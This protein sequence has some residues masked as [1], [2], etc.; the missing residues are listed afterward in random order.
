[1]TNATLRRT[2][3]EH[4]Q[5]PM[6]WH[7]A[8]ELAYGLGRTNVLPTQDVPLERANGRVLAAPLHAR[9]MVPGFDNAAMDGYAVCGPGPWRIV[10]QILAG[11]V[12]SQALAPGQ[13]TEIA[14]GAPVP[15]G[16]ER[17]VEYEITAR[18][19][20]SL[21][22]SPG[23]RDHIRRR[24]EYVTEGQH[25]LPIGEKLTPAAIG[26]AASTGID[27]MTVRRQP[28]VRLLITGDEIT[29]HGIPGHGTIRDAIGPML[30]TLLRQWNLDAESERV[31]DRPPH[32]P[33]NAVSDA[34]RRNDITL[35]CGSSSVGPA[36]GLHTT[37]HHIGAQVNIDGVACR[38]GHPQLLAHHDGHW[39]IGV[40]GNPYA[41]LV[42][43]LTLLDP[44]LA[45][46]AGREL[47]ELATAELNGDVKTSA[48]CTRLLPVRL[49]RRRAHVIDGAHSGFLG[50]A[51]QADALAVIAPQ[52]H[53]EPVELLPITG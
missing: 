34:L 10:G 32:I 14:T 20:D 1:M 49:H 17:V 29:D 51:A 47:P 11:E 25:L 36:D 33:Y 46:L 15:L 3:T 23:P 9:T 53:G 44:L 8:R 6:S 38:P 30:G 27:T 19:G 28:S 43:V 18:V 26:L 21:S 35:V 39:L 24:G 41:A 42:S 4:A 48:D 40:P 5:Q 2:A 22:A 16:T 50:P 7:R 12:P 31:A 13:A 45:G 52:W 37:L